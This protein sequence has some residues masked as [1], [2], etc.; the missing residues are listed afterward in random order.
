MSAAAVFA[1]TASQYVGVDSMFEAME[2]C[3]YAMW[4]N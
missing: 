4:V 2:R 3:D 1:L